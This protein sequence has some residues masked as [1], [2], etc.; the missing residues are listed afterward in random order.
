MKKTSVVIAM[1]II[2]LIFATLSCVLDPCLFSPQSIQCS[3]R[4]ADMTA[5]AEEAKF[6]K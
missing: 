5:T 1:V 4:I 6:N 2:L 3:I